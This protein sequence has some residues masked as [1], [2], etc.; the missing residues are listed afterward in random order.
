MENKTNE[1]IRYTSYRLFLEKGY[2][3]TNIRDIC[4]E[5]GIKTSTLYFYYKSKQELFYS[6]YNEIFESLI[7]FIQNIEELRQDIS[8]HIKLFMFYKKKIEYYAQ[9]ISAQKFILRYF[10]FPSDEILS[11]IRENYNLWTGIE[12]DIL[13]DIINQCLERKILKRSRSVDDYLLEYRKFES[14]KTIQMIVYNIK[15]NEKEIAN[16]WSVFWESTMV[17]TNPDETWQ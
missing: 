9:D 14:S 6:I 15:M 12:S 11:F 13:K 4:N 16:S 2:E 7:K 1:I 5:V 8:P 10:L 3:A 17:N